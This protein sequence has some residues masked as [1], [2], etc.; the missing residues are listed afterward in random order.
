[1]QTIREGMEKLTGQ[2]V[3]R[4]R[5]EVVSG[6]RVYRSRAR[7]HS[8]LGSTEDERMGFDSGFETLSV[9]Q[10]YKC[11]T[12]PAFQLEVHLARVGTVHVC[13]LLSRKQQKKYQRPE[14]IPH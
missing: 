14:R 10:R 12:T 8:E 7:L 1:M 5:E 2:I 11:F 3:W 6:L 13:S 4:A 9:C